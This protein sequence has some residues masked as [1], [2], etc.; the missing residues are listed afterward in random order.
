MIGFFD[1][2]KPAKVDFVT[3]RPFEFD[4][5]E[6]TVY[7]KVHR[8]FKCNAWPKEWSFFEG[9]IKEVN[10]PENYPMYEEEWK[11]W[12]KKHRRKYTPLFQKLE[13]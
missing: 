7:G 10:D 4:K 3:K 13:Q 9:S 11:F 8:Y 6:G 12:C 2:G 5:N 1:K